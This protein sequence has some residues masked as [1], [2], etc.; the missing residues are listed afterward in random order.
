MKVI[1]ENVE[2]CMK[3][4]AVIPTKEGSGT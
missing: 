4:G 1:T 2:C 3:L